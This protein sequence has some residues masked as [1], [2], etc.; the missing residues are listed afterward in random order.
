MNLKGLTFRRDRARPLTTKV[1]PQNIE[2]LSWEKIPH[3]SYFLNFAYSEYHLFSSLQNYLDR[4]NFKSDE[5]I[6][7]LLLFETARF[8]LK[9]ACK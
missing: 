6:E 8:F 5:E 4:L 7:T 3:Q 1:T 2:K 9:K